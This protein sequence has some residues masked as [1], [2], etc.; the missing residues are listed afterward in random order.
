MAAFLWCSSVPAQADFTPPENE[1]EFAE[2]AAELGRLSSSSLAEVIG[3]PRVVHAEVLAGLE[4][5]PQ[6]LGSD[7]QA[8]LALRSDI[9]TARSQLR[10]ALDEQ[11][12]RRGT[13]ADSRR[14]LALQTRNLA[15]AIEDRERKEQNLRTMSVDAFISGSDQPDLAA[16]V[17][18]TADNAASM[19]TQSLR[20]TQLATAATDDL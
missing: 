19:A 13:V 9:E 11:R 4:A 15:A 10:W 3:N 14:L 8:L 17:Q 18:A 6:L 12:V 20:T 1:S 5:T 7:G 2:P 16:L